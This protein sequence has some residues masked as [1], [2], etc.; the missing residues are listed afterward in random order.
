MEIIDGATSLLE[1]SRASG[2][3]S[4][5]GSS[6]VQVYYAQARN[7]LAAGNYLV[8]YLQQALGGIT[9][10]LGSQLSAQ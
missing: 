6:L 1:T 4:Y 10:R 5:N 7:E 3:T 8:P 2:N 9:G